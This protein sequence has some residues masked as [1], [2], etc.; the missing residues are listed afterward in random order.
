MKYHTSECAGWVEISNLLGPCIVFRGHPFLFNLCYF[1][2]IHFTLVT[3]AITV[4]DMFPLSFDV[5]NWLF[6]NSGSVIACWEKKKKGWWALLDCS[7]LFSAPGNTEAMNP[8]F[9][10]LCV[11]LVKSLNCSRLHGSSCLKPPELNL[12]EAGLRTG[13]EP[14]FFPR[15]GHALKMAF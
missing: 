4:G 5:S 2:I 1:M 6:Q 15:S 9:H 14:D 12:D 10:T 13:R 8:N 7:F 11:T 3:R